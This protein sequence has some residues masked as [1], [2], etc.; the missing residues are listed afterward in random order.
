MFEM[1][2]FGFDYRKL[3]AASLYFPMPQTTMV[4]DRPKQTVPLVR[5]MPLALI[6]AFS[7]G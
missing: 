4:I 6:D 2:E 3:Y 7:L 1:L 5:P